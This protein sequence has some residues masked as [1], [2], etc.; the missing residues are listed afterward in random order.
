MSVARPARVLHVLPDLLIGGGQTIVLNHLR[1]ADR[2]RYDVRVCQLDPHD[3]MR[4]AFVEAGVD[5][6]WLRHDPARERDTVR[7]LA[8]LVRDGGVDLLHV[9]SDSDRKLAQVAALLT[10]TPVVG[11]LHAEW[12]H[13]GDK[14]PPG[15]PLPQRLLGRAKGGLR[16]WVERR[17]VRAY[18]A[19]SKDVARLFRPLVTQDITVLQQSIP[20]ERFDA[21]ADVDPGKVR[22]D[23]GVPAEGPLLVCVSRLVPGKG[24]HH[25]VAMLARLRDAWPDAQLVLVGDGPE[26][27]ALEAAARDA[28]VGERV[29]LVGNRMDVPAILVAADV[30][31]FGSESEGFGL[32]LLEAMA[33][34]TA[35]VAFRLP[36]FGEFARDGVTTDLV[37]V[38]DVA[39]L[40]ERVDA[41]L[42]DPARRAAMGAAGQRVVRERF[43]ST[44]VARTFEQVYDRVLGQRR[45]ATGEA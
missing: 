19:E 41:L 8:R 33:A 12:V 44:A 32:A 37:D 22:A 25:L 26:R 35:S 9:H 13:L 43:D 18:V 28:G 6:V 15:A 16:D 30:F 39:A 36:A 42:R 23:L 20:V 4:P 31:V 27:A 10:G 5:P 34:G 38:G 17:T 40:S 29:H 2:A 3:D 45:D 14:T 7:R 21:V 1:H 11:H 24:Q